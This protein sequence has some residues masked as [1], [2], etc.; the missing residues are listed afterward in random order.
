MNYK[1]KPQPV[2]PI[3]YGGECTVVVLTADGHPTVCVARTNLGGPRREF[4]SE[5]VRRYFGTQADGSP[6]EWEILEAPLSR[7]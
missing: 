7:P 3:P 5:V 4:V 2:K 6:H 1:T